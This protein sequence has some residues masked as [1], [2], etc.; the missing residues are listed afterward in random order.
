M[1]YTIILLG[2]IQYTI[3]VFQAAELFRKSEVS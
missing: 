2:I 1:L 3:L